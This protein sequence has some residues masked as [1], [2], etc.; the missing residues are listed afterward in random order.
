MTNSS[1][2]SHPR[3]ETE[4]FTVCVILPTP[5]CLL[6]RFGGAQPNMAVNKACWCRGRRPER[7]GRERGAPLARTCK[8]NFTRPH[9]RGN[10]ITPLVAGVEECVTNALRCRAEWRGW[11]GGV[12]VRRG[13]VVRP[14]NPLAPPPPPPPDTSWVRPG[15][16][17]VPRT[18]ALSPPPR[19]QAAARRRD[20]TRPPFI[21][22]TWF[23]G[24]N[25]GLQPR[26]LRGNSGLLSSWS[27]STGDD[28]QFISSCFFCLDHPQ[29]LPCKVSSTTSQWTIRVL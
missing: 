27:S 8:W 24:R 18:S 14:S 21:R 15:S 1:N 3:Q 23:N 7:V 12:G 20:Q 16:L 9:C 22:E 17:P 4:I 28:A 2:K 11:V 6:C 19:C 5:C 10:W 29:R 13:W 26:S 25:W